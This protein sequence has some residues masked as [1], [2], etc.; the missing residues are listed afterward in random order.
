M[1]N[2]SL[3]DALAANMVFANEVSKSVKI[4]KA[5]ATT[6]STAIT[7]LGTA[8]SKVEAAKYATKQLEQDNKN[9]AD[10]LATFNGGN[11]TLF[12]DT[13][14]R[15]EYWQHRATES[16]A[17]A[18]QALSDASTALTAMA[19]A[20]AAFADGTTTETA[21]STLPT[22]NAPVV[23]YLTLDLA[24]LARLAR[25][26][27]RPSAQRHVAAAFVQTLKPHRPTPL[28]RL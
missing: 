1:L 27:T 6:F 17:Q 14:T 5:T 13:R 12:F 22:L 18:T 3:D 9:A 20:Y 10:A 2:T 24:R 26:D 21:T 28:P 11:G 25:E 16:N 23:N 15:L 7:S 4:T 8:Q 19:K